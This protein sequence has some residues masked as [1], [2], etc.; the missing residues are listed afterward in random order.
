LLLIDA[1]PIKTKE[2]VR[3]NRH[4]KIG[5]SKLIKKT[6]MLVT[7]HRKNVGIMGIR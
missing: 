2:I 6:V 1:M 3:K 7:I 4:E 5:I